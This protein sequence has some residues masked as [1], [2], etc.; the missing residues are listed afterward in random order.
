MF[1][2]LFLRRFIFPRGG[3]VLQLFF[4]DPTGFFAFR[5]AKIKEYQVILMDDV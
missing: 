2:K 3:S 4:G 1:R 5:A